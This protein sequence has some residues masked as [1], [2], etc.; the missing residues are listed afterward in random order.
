M[1]CFILFGPPGAGKGTQAAL[2]SGLLSVPHISTGD[3][4]RA[5]VSEKSPLGVKAQ[6]YLDRGELV[7]DE[8]VIDMIHVRLAQEDAQKGWL[9]DGFPRTV[10]Q[11]HALD[12]LLTSID[13]T[14]D[15]VLNLSVSDEF[16]LDRLLGRGRKDDT[17][18][19]IRRRLQVYHEQTAPLIQFYRDR[20]QL[21]DVDGSSPVE[22]VTASIE[23]AVKPLLA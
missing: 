19:V 23:E 9:L 5:A 3:L 4:F 14:I 13:Q 22:V 7:P 10:P 20:N 16:L 21:T 18:D 2:L 11:A 12:A 15:V 1:A 6:G 17:E 8:V